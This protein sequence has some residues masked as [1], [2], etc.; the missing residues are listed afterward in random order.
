ME[1][2]RAARKFLEGLQNRPRQPWDDVADLSKKLDTKPSA[3][4]ARKPAPP[5]RKPRPAANDALG[6]AARLAERNREVA[7]KTRDLREN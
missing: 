6:Q 2:E 3:A 5:A 4:P 1:D 7:R